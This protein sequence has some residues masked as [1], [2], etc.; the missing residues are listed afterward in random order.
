MADFKVGENV[1]F[2]LESGAQGYGRVVAVTASEYAIA[3]EAPDL[4]RLSNASLGTVVWAL[5]GATWR[6]DV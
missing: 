2:E 6:R 5:K 4:Q 3:Y 1:V